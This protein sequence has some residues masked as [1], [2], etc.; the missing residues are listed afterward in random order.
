MSFSIAFKHAS[1]PTVF[2]DDVGPGR[3]GLIRV[4]DLAESFFAVTTVWS[5][6][7]YE[8]SWAEN[9]SALRRGRDAFFLT[10]VSD[11][12]DAAVFFVWPAFHLDGRIYT[13]QKLLLRSN[14]RGRFGIRYVA[15][16]IDFDGLRGL[17]GGEVS[18]FPIDKEDLPFTC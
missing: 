1:Q 16:L 14:A 2:P 7:D 6:N 9:L 8:R 18:F 15:D 17:V 4:G 10:D 12:D 5:E 3:E 11:G 13:T